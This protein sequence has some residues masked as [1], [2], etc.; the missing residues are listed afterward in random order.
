MEQK[1]KG[2]YDKL[3]EFDID[4]ERLKYRK[5]EEEKIIIPIIKT[6]SL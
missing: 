2:F 4:L 1:Y 6:N 5:D 3:K